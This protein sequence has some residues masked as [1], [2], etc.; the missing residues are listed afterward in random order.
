LKKAAKAWSVLKLDAEARR[1]YDGYIK[2]WRIATSEVKTSY[3][4]GKLDGRKEGIE[5]GEKMGIE[6]G[7]KMGIEKGE[8]MGEEKAMRK[9][10]MAMLGAGDSEEKVMALTGLSE[11]EVKE[12]KKEN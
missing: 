8:K 10:A 5:E 3:I 4:D 9:V 12:L 6:K 11:R 1:E 7:E 2:D